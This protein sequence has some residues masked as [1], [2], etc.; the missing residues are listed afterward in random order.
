MVGSVMN[1]C[2]LGATGRSGRRLVSAA[3]DN[4]HHVTAVARDPARLAD[5]AHD[6]LTVRVASLSEHA[7]LADVL[8]GHDA[9]INVAGY[10]A[11]GASFTS[12]V[13]NVIA[14]VES[15]L[16]SGGRFW[17]FGGAALLDV[18][19]TAITTLDLPGIP[20]IFEAHRSNFERVKRSPLDWSMLCPGPMIPAPDGK[21]TDSLVVS[22]DVWPVARPSYTHLLPR[23]ALSL[24]F[25]NSIPRMTVHY[26]DAAKVILDNLARRGPMSLKRVGIALRSESRRR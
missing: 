12:L 3:I 8:R 21:S 6:R 5:L 19:G 1:I 15:A 16:G 26:E 13:A 9:V 20:K 23:V 10:V 25:K 14:A 24:V 11:D 17:L 4:G 2:V 18:P 7:A 22:Q